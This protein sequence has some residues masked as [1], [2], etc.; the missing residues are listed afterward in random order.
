MALVGA[1]LGL[2]AFAGPAAA[3]SQPLTYTGQIGLPRLVAPEGVAVDGNG[4]VIVAEPTASG[5]S[6]NDRIAKYSADGNFLDVIA[7]PGT[8][9]GEVFDPSDVAVAANGDIYTIDRGND[10][11]QR[12]DDLGNFIS[13]IGQNGTGAGQFRNPDGVAVD[14]NGLVYVADSG[15]YRVQV[16]DPTLLPGDPLV[17]AWCVVDGGI[18]GCLSSGT[19]VGIAVSGSTVYTIGTGVVRTF[20]AT[21]GAPGTT[22]NSSGAAGVATDAGGHVW[23]ASTTN[24]FVS[25]YSSGGGLLTTEGKGDLTDP[26]GLAISG[27]HLYVADTGGGR[28]VRFAPSALD[29]SW[30]VSGATGVAVDASVVYVADGGNVDTYSTSGVA[31]ISWSSPG[32][33]GITVD[34]S[35]N[36]WVSSSTGVVT[37]YDGS[38]AVLNTFGS[39][40]LTS[41]QGI[42]VSGG[43]LFVA[44]SSKIFRFATAA[45]AAPET[46]WAVS[47]VTGVTVNG[48]TL[49]AAA[50]NSVRAFTTDGAA[51]ASWAATGSYGIAQDA[52]GNL[53]VSST[54]SALV[55]E[56]NSAGVLLGTVGTGLSTPR[57]VA[58][59]GAKLF[60]ADNGAGKVFRFSLLDYQL[61]WG[62]WPGPGVL[63]LP[64]GVAVDA[65][66]NIYATNKAANSVDKFA[67]DGSFLLSMTGS[68]IT[69]LNNPTAVAIGPTGNV[70]VADTNNHRIEVFD[71]SGTYLDRW[72]SNGSTPGQF[73]LP[74]GIAVDASGFVYVA[75]TNNHR[76]EKFNGSTHALVWTKGS[77]GTSGGLFKSPKGLALDASGNIWIADSANNRVQELD[78][79]GNFVRTWGSSGT[80]NLQFTT[81]S[82]IEIDGA[83]LIYVSDKGNNRVQI[84]TPSGAYLSTLGSLGLGTGRF[85]SPIGLAI[86]PTSTATRLLVADSV[87][88]RVE[89]FIDNNGPDTTL[90]SWPAP[91]THLTAASFTFSANDIGATFECKIDGAVSW[92]PTCNGSG[93]GSASYSGLTEGD[94]DFAVRAFDAANNPGNPTTYSWTIDNTAPVVSLTGGPAE[95]QFSNDAQPSFDFD[96]DEPVQGFECSLDGGAFAACS[97]G[98]SFAVTDGAHTFVVRATDQAG[99]VGVSGTRHWTTDSTPPT[100]N[101]T[102]GPS[103]IVAT[104]T[105]TFQ[106]NSPSDGGS[107]TFQCD[108]DG[109]GFS[110]CTSPWD[111]PTPPVPDGQHTF[112]VFAT[113]THGNSSSPVQRKWTVDTAI[114]RPDALIA[115]GATYIGNDIYN[116]NGS[117]QTKTLKTKVGSTAIF[118]IQVQN[119]GGNADTMHVKGPGS[120]NGYTVT[121]LLGTTNVTSAVKAGTCSVD[122]NAGASKVITLKVKVGSSAALSK[123]LLVKVTSAADT[124][125][126]DAVKAIVKRA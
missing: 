6:T 119:D 60:V 58:I 111:Y 36:V 90:L 35:G 37:E 73:N 16:F 81:P 45:P 86:D 112:K 21:S 97:T 100:V 5:T 109:G 61:Q 38:G 72:G 124:T 56:F 99:N 63:D 24:D 83:G 95:G 102:S 54:T 51:G 80:G 18:S 67:P 55:R 10:R 66:G 82:D 4:D 76:I 49:Y 89:V 33:S 108:I 116:S 85:S 105:A 87:N 123:T 115:T 68:G 14:V 17:N 23:V 26:Q 34:D 53:W 7:G 13:A 32:A 31:G 88:H 74:S 15:N 25:E 59:A 3:T 106:F 93:S 44:D 1:L 75:D 126:V 46:S 47:S 30:S 65:T 48:G 19:V 94:H 114:K 101:I 8:A 70:Y 71:P 113:D 120:A 52:S 40:S 117:S 62:Q 118:K 92:D 69:L 27:G 43:K 122:L 96:A 103:G 2:G 91:K 84:V 9:N 42:D 28:I 78:A 79:A 50:G 64:S 98:D 110:P 107:A 22:W 41:P 125:K 12:F 57:G 20:D 11:L 39:G 77:F 29:T 104:T 121:Y